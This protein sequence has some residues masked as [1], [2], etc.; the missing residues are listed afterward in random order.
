M[1]PLDLDADL[2]PSARHVAHV[3]QEE[4][5]LTQQEI[6]E[7]TRHPER[8]VDDAL[9]RLVDEGFADWRQ[10][11]HDARRRRYYLVD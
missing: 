3:L 6:V 1:K 8:T 7:L 4:G 5:S 11:W 10:E 2:P 9:K